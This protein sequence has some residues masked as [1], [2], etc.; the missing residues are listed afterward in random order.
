MN[1][2]LVALDF[3]DS[4]K[5]RSVASSLASH[6]GGFKVGLE[7]IMSSGPSVVSEIADLGLPVFADVKLHDIPNTVRG[8]AR[9]VGSHGARWLTV[10]ATGGRSMIEAAIEGMS[11]HRS[12][13]GNGVLVVTVLTSL[14]SGDLNEVGLGS[15]VGTASSALA[16]LAADVGAEGIVCSPHEVASSASTVPSIMKVT[17]GIRPKGTDP[18]DQKRVAT[19]QQALDAGA[20]WLV[21]G[22]AITAAADPVGA[23]QGIAASLGVGVQSEKPGH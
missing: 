8:A 19:P 9:A 21:V 3:D 18:Q 16:A 7:L 1:P 12:A 20:D 17:P 6:V 13:E 15:G 5:A 11:T 22:R 10:H 23:A 2:V 4:S 14:N